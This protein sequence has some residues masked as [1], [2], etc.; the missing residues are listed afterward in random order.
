MRRAENI[1][2]F[3]PIL[4]LKGLDRGSAP[5]R[6]TET[7]MPRHLARAALALH[8]ARF[9]RLPVS[10]LE[11]LAEGV[12]V[13]STDS[14]TEPAEI[15]AYDRYGKRP[16]VRAVAAPAA[17]DISTH[18]DRTDPVGCCSPRV[19][20]RLPSGDLREPRRDHRPGNPG[21]APA[22]TAD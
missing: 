11:P 17:E 5:V 16:P 4:G 7:D 2:T 21:C 13:V 6:L 20:P 22:T 3:L 19:P 9:E 8:S 14:P 10:L 12:P 18:E 1:A 15:L